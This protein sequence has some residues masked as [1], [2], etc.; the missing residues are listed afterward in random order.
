MYMIANVWG[1]A[2]NE[3]NSGVVGGGY[4]QAD[5]AGGSFSIEMVFNGS[6]SQADAA[7][8]PYVDWIKAN[9]TLVSITGGAVAAFPSMH[10]WH[11]SW[12]PGSEPTGS[13]SNIG[14]RLFPSAAMKDDARRARLALNLTEIAA[15]LGGLEG[16]VVCGGVTQQLDR[17]S[18]ST[19]VTPA[20]RD[21]GVHIVLGA[22]WAL[23]ATIAEQQ[24]VRTGL[25]E[26]TGILRAEVPES[27]AYFSESD[28]LEPDFGASYWGAANYAQLQGIKQRYDPAGLFGCHNCVELP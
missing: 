21:A 5:L 9:P 14:S 23:N 26:L 16:L 10:A 24:S 1:N 12:D 3:E 11:S 6:T 15:Y 20:W 27:G 17:D 8:G 25:S 13:V 7:V 18:A 22:G 4:F 2:V 19:S 28:F